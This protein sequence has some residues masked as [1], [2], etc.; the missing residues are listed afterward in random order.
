MRTCVVTRTQADP[1]GFVR[2]V[3]SPEGELLVDY[4]CRLPGR[5]AWVIPVKANLLKLE[6][7]PK[8]LN[9]SLRANVDTRG[10]LAKVCSANRRYLCDALSLAARSGRLVSGQKATWEFVGA[11]RARAVGFANDASPRLVAGF[12]AKFPELKVYELDLN[13]EEL[14]ARIGKG[15]RAVFALGPGQAQHPL[16]IELGRMQALR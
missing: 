14:G 16:M 4:R 13:R 12:G 3:L 2:L 1:S 11:G 8:L 6:S 10:L 5:G 15:S 9:R 7:T